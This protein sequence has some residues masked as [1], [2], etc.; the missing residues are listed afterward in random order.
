MK[1]LNNV[2]CS[3]LFLLTVFLSTSLIAL[4]QS[5]QFIIS[6]LCTMQ[7]EIRCPE[8]FKAACSDEKAEGTIPKCVFLGKNYVP[9]CW[10]FIRKQKIDFTIPSEGLRAVAHESDVKIIGGG[11]T[12]NLNRETIGCRKL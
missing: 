1:K 11:E 10:K 7:G 5:E 12:Y 2:S 6:P 4:S 9:G 3:L 8:G